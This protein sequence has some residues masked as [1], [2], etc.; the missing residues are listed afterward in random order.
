MKIHE[1]IRKVGKKSWRLYSK[2]GKNLGTYGSRSG[3]EKR[4]REVQYFKHAN[5]SQD[6]GPDDQE[7][8]P[9]VAQAKNLM[10]QILQAAQRDYDNWYE[11]QTDT[12]A[13]GGICHIIAESI[14][15]VLSDAG[16]NCVTVSCSHEQHVYVAAQF[17]EGVYTIDIPYYV[18]EEGG[19]FSWRKLPD[20]KFDANDVVFYKVSGDPA[21]FADYIEG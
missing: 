3:A 2:S 21:D 1:I 16:I 12:Y 14:C 18:Y 5:E 10:P 19:G 11:S 13:G 15:D 8:F 20:I 9:S 4:E 17:D 7:Q 6:S